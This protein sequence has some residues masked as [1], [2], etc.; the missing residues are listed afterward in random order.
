MMYPIKIESYAGTTPQIVF[1]TEQITI[2]L[3]TVQDKI[4]R[5]AEQ[6]GLNYTKFYDTIKCEN[7]RLDPSKQSDII[8]N[9]S[10]PRRNIVVG[11]RERSYGLVM[12]HLPDH[13]D[14]TEEQAKDP[15]FALN[16]MA[17]Q[18]VKNN[19]SWWTCYKY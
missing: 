1:Q 3:E 13:P 12:I 9:F 17:Q 11:T 8:Y 18:W 14:V 15:D 6:Y 16:W 2:K 19:Q 10:D 5:Y 7:R 4:A